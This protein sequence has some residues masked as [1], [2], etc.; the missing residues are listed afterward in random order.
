VS[1]EVEVRSVEKVIIVRLVGQLTAVEYAKIFDDPAFEFNMPALWDISG[2]NLT[3]VAISE[4]RALPKLLGQFSERRGTHYR[5][6]IVT[7]R[8]IDFQLVRLY[9]ALLK[10]IGSFRMKVFINSREGLV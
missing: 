4:V 6:A 7:N 3:Q 5:A 10:L 1:V 2:L 8:T 9:S